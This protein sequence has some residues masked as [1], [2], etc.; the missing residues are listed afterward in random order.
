MTS[1][2]S[3]PVGI[4]GLALAWES[5]AVVVGR[6]PSASESAGSCDRGALRP[7]VRPPSRASASSRASAASPP[8][9]RA[10]SDVE[11]VARAL[12]DEIAPLFRVGF[13]ALTFVS[14]DA[15]EASGFLARAAGKDVDWWPDVRVD[16]VRESSGIASAVFEASSFAVYDVAGSS[17]EFTACGRDG[18][19]ERCV[20]AAHQRRPGD[21]GDLRRDDRRLSRVFIRRSRGHADPRLGGD[22]RARAH[23]HGARA[24]R[25]TAAG[26]A[27]RVD[28]PAA[29]HRARSRRRP[30]RRRRG[31]RPALGA[32]RSFVRL[33][34]SVVCRWSRIAR[35]KLTPQRRPSSAGFDSRRR[36]RADGCG[37][38]R[39][40]RS[41][42]ARAARSVG[43]STFAHSV[44]ALRRRRRSSSQGDRSAC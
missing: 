2:E 41:R 13:V 29:A 26:A 7:A 35:R 27:A 22:D 18:R 23:T 32:A 36:E 24:R 28:R 1:T 42:A 9:S 44:R 16:L 20:R 21:R 19:E 39:R 31:A 6:S 10:R 43:S 25:C 33:G 11:G 17:R 4:N 38:R 30:G 8:S 34:D 12:L 15:R 40:R 14:D 5:V 3:F 37:R